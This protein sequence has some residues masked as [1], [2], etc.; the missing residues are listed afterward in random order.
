MASIEN[1]PLPPS[2]AQRA[3]ES[4]NPSLRRANVP[5]SNQHVSV[6]VEKIENG[7]LVRKHAHS[8]AADS[9]RSET[10]FTPTMPKIEVV[11]EMDKTPGD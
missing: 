5:V 10:T 2:G 4:P 1:I 6:H 11:V 7:Y 3:A 8:D 9:Y